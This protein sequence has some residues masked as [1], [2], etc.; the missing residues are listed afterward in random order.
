MSIRT[1][2]RRVMDIVGLSFV[3]L[4]VVLIPLAVVWSILRATMRLLY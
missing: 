3:A 4:G 1:P 2:P